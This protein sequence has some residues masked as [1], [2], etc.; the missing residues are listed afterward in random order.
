MCSRDLI[1]IVL[2]MHST[3]KTIDEK[4]KPPSVNGAHIENGGHKQLPNNTSPV[5][6]F[7]A[8]VKTEDDKVITTQPIM[9]VCCTCAFI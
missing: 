5:K 6:S 2:L 1:T 7:Y 8:T 4:V 3:E 9:E